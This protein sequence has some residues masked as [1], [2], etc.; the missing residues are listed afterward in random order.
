M[1]ENQ[2][3]I[4]PKFKKQLQGFLTDESGKVTKTDVLKLGIGAMMVGGVAGD[5]SAATHGN[6]CNTSSNT[7]T[8]SF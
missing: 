5:A 3:K 4:F 7:N 6:G 8:V 1:S 2:K